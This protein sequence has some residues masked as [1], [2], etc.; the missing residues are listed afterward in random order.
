MN[1]LSSDKCHSS[2]ELLRR[3][4]WVLSHLF[5]IIISTELLYIFDS[6][7]VQAV[8][9]WIMFL[10]ITCSLLK[11][12]SKAFVLLLITQIVYGISSLPNLQ[13]HRYLA[14]FIN[15]GLL[16]LYQKDS[17]FNQRSIWL[18]SRSLIV[19]YFFAVFHKLNS[20][21]L[22]PTVSCA[23]QFS[24]HIRI[25]FPQI[26]QLPQLEIYGA[27]IIE[28]LICFL[29]FSQKT[30]RMAAVLA[31][32]FHLTLSFDYIKLFINFSGVMIG[33]VSIITIDPDKTN[34]LLNKRFSRLI[35]ICL[36]LSLLVM[37]LFHY[38]QLIHILAVHFT[39]IA[40]SLGA[41]LCIFQSNKMYP[42]KASF[43]AAS[44]IFVLF[45]DGASPYLG[46]K[47]R[48]S[49]NMYSNLLVSTEYSNHFLISKG[50]NIFGIDQ[51]AESAL[52]KNF[53]PMNPVDP[54]R[55]DLCLW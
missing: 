13:N 27:L 43:I 52:L 16:V 48:G 22:D 8:L 34:F 46:I 33:L 23:T 39:F 5:F 49:F 28:A 1:Q 51:N 25:L 31:I 20:A 10:L 41:L 14:L 36:A 47:N 26:P 4:F 15:I 12:Q 21:F 24:N 44:I 37:K 11:P 7:S 55:R 45:I 30:W 17:F 32:L 6:L 9:P 53:L 19:V 40:F 35:P 2:T 18:I 50:L 54:E 29:L 3:Q 38:N 42:I